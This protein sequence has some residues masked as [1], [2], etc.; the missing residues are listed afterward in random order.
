[1]LAEP[2]PGLMLISWACLFLFLHSSVQ[3]FPSLVR[4]LSV[5]LTPLLTEM[6][7]FLF[8]LCRLIDFSCNTAHFPVDFHPFFFE[9]VRKTPSPL[10]LLD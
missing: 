7:I 3:F 5:P 6:V 4:K 8:F 10:S 2:F 1:M 9:D